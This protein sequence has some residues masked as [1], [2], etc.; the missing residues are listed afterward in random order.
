MQALIHQLSIA[1][2]EVVPCVRHCT[3][4]VMDTVFILSNCI[5]TQELEFSLFSEIKLRLRNDVYQD[6]PVVQVHGRCS[7][8]SY[9]FHFPL[10]PSFP[11]LPPPPL[12]LHQTTA[13][14]GH[15]HL[16]F[17]DRKQTL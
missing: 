12:L 10:P 15:F 6:A 14:T 3:G 16:C 4:C 11:P 13:R 7:V 1:I 2:S 5:E 8:Y 17:P 9:S